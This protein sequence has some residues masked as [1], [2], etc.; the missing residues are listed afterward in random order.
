MTKLH[1]QSGDD[2][3]PHGRHRTGKEGMRR[4]VSYSSAD[5][6]TRADAWVRMC[7]LWFDDYDAWRAALL[8][9]PPAFTAPHWSGEFPYVDIVSIFTGAQSEE[10]E[11]GR[12]V[13]H[14]CCASSIVHEINTAGVIICACHCFD[15]GWEVCWP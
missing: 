2:A 6:L 15:S 4:F 11:E 8:D 3:R 5:P 1:I 9:S 14:C 13:A 10:S 7:E 12:I